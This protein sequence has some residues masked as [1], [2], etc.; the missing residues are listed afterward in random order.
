LKKKTRDELKALGK[1]GE[2]WNELIKRL[3]HVYKNCR[4]IK[5]YHDVDD[6]YKE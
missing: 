5:G 3:I 4:D 1:K 6:L 2:S